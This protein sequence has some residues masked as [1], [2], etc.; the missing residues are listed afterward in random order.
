MK[1]SFWSLLPAL[2]LALALLPASALAAEE[3]GVG[4]ADLSDE[5]IQFGG[6][7]KETERGVTLLA[8]S[9]TKT[10][11]KAAIL[12]ALEAQAESIDVSSYGLTVD[13]G[14]LCY[15]EVLNENPELFY[16]SGGFSWKS[17]EDTVVEITPE[18][19]GYT[20]E[21][22]RTFNAVCDSILAQL[23]ASMT[24]EQKYLFL[25][26]YLVTHCYYDKSLT[27]HNAY[28]ALVDGTAV[29][30]GY[31]EAYAC[32]AKLA[33][34]SA[35]VVSS[36]AQ[37]HA[38]NLVTLD[39]ERYYVDCT[40]DDPL[41]DAEYYCGHTN[42]LRS[43]DAMHTAKDSG[44]TGHSAGTDWVDP[45][46][47]NVYNTVP[48][49]TKYDSYFWQDVTVALPMLNGCYGYA[50]SSDH[51]HVYLR[52]AGGT[53]T[54]V[55][56][57]EG[58]TEEATWYVWGDASH[59]WSD[60]YITVTALGNSLYFNTPA[61]IYSL[62]MT[63]T[64]E[65]V[66][67]RSEEEQSI[68]YIYGLA[69]GDGCLY[70]YLGQDPNNGNTY[71]RRTYRYPMPYEIEEIEIRNGEVYVLVCNNSGPDYVEVIAA[72]YDANGRLLD[73]AT[74]VDQWQAGVDGEDRSYIGMDGLSLNDAAT[75]RAFVVDYNTFAPL[76]QSFTYQL[77]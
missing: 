76:S 74:R 16:V 68:G 26:D 42:F 65:K 32:L 5:L 73:C 8:S 59:I 45:L 7:P 18:Y 12:A 38:W 22:I 70:Y 9:A 75:I 27:R 61:A 69:A 46:G 1:K 11:A 52:A 48:G 49:G 60:S 53:E 43:R 64:I 24:D 21:Q 47:N 62:A 72:A 29:C 23:D 19:E 51:D 34:L 35:P 57:G 6:F 10:Q 31:S 44:G 17:R 55:S 77:P 40:W 28:D 37:D 4:Y 15:K 30:Q 54:P 25:H 41:N 50:K 2:C 56:I 71:V 63:G 14:K 3:T 33:G 20:D 39:G 58:T 13:E 36:E 66:Y 67:D